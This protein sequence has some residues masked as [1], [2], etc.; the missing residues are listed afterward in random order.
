MK[1]QQF[2]IESC[3]VQKRRANIAD[4]LIGLGLPRQKLFG[5]AKGW[6][7]S[8]EFK[9]IFWRHQ[10]AFTGRCKLDRIPHDHIPHGGPISVR[11][12]PSLNDCRPLGHGQAL[13][14]FLLWTLGGANGCCELL[15]DLGHNCGEIPRCNRC[16]IIGRRAPLRSL[17]IPPAIVLKE[18]PRP[19]GGDCLQHPSGFW[20]RLFDL[21]GKPHEPFG[22]VTGPVAC[23]GQHARG[24]GASGLG[25]RPVGDRSLLDAGEC[26]HGRLWLSFG[27]RLVDGLPRRGPRSSRNIFAASRAIRHKYASK[28]KRQRPSHN[29]RGSNANG[30]HNKVLVGFK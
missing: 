3:G 5:G 25:P 20:W 19:V 29:A 16:K 14:H 30:T 4:F 2:A 21:L 8:I 24:N 6:S 17:L 23:V 15:F 1:R 11:H 18:P 12:F 10:A 28:K 26:R 27:N 13:E 9:R 22:I 7:S